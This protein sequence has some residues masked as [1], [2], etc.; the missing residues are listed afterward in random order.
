MSRSALLLLLFAACAAPQQRREFRDGAPMRTPVVEPRTTYTPTGAGL[1]EYWAEPDA[2][3]PERS[4]YT[5]VLPQTPETMKGPGIWAV[6]PPDER[7]VKVLGVL[8]PLGP[9]IHT[10]EDALPGEHCGQEAAR[11]FV[12]DAGLMKEIGR[13]SDKEKACLVG[14]AMMECLARQRFVREQ[15]IASFDGQPP[16]SAVENMDAIRRTIDGIQAFLDVACD[17]SYS[18]AVRALAEWWSLKTYPRAK[19]TVH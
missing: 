19:G 13:I 6:K 18:P 15:H 1:S 16:R 9:D 11:G 12:S 14:T 10:Q 4:P 17:A 2:P 8:V 7:A 5:R 3:K